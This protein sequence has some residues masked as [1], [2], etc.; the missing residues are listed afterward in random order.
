[1]SEPLVYTVEEACALLKI[2]RTAGYEAARRGD[3]PGVIRIGRTLRVSRYALEQVLNGHGPA[4]EGPKR[5]GASYEP[6]PRRKE[7]NTHEQPTSTAGS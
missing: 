4:D 3:L 2:G 7:L 5:N 1:M 6:A